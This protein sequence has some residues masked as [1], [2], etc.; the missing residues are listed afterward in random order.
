MAVRELTY[1]LIWCITEYVKYSISTLETNPQYKTVFK[2]Y[3][4]TIFLCIPSYNS[5]VDQSNS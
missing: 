2:P 3:F 5:K 4:K 1:R